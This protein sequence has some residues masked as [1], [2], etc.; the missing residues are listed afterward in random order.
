MTY[1]QTYLQSLWRQNTVIQQKAWSRG[2]W[3]N[4]QA[5]EGDTGEMRETDNKKNPEKVWRRLFFDISLTTER[6]SLDIVAQWMSIFA[7]PVTRF[8][9]A[10]ISHQQLDGLKLKFCAVIHGPQVMSLTDFVALS[11]KLLM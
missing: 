9:Q 2:G 10:E 3:S 6:K 1:W 8:V 7:L 11:E 5:E 4:Q